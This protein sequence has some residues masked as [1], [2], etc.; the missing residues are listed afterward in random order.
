MYEQPQKVG[1][2]VLSFLFL[3]L[4][5][6]PLP[7]KRASS[8]IRSSARLIHKVT[9]GRSSPSILSPPFGCLLFRPPP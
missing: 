3:R 8:L 9:A 2:F 7:E 1:S 6:H 5:P 4:S